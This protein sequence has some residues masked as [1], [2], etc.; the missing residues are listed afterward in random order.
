MYLLKLALRPWRVAP[1]SQAFAAMAVG[2]LLVLSAFLFW[3]ERG[4]K[5]VVHRM[6]SEQVITAYLDPSLENLDEGKL[7]DSIQV[8]LGAKSVDVKVVGSQQ[9]VDELKGHYPELSKEL[10]SL[11]QE[12]NSI[13]PRYVSVSG[14]LPASAVSAVKAVPGIESAETSSDRYHHIVGAFGALRWVARLLAVGLC[15][16]LMTGLI[17]LSRM[18]SYLHRESIR[19]MKLWG[20][21]ALTLRT[22]ALLSG[23]WVG[24]SGGVIAAVGWVTGGIWLA[25]H[26]K[27]LSPLLKDMALPQAQMAAGLLILG[28]LIGAA[29]GTFGGSTSQ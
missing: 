3:M 19:L 1:W 17:H 14:V 21:S 29:A 22:P 10:Q 12:V 27:A 4:L 7:V 18:N 9:F 13:V 28:A 23:L 15:L 26:V 16:A 6:K 25:E 11:G 20:A 24:I 8:A 5:P 2:F